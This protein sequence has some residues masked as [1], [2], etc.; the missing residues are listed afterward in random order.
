MP[1]SFH[2]A[3]L[4]VAP[5]GMPHANPSL[6]LGL[7]MATVPAIPSFLTWPQLPRRSFREQRFVQSAAGFPGLVIDSTSRRV[8]VD[9]AIAERDLDRLSLAYL[10]HDIS[11]GAL[12]E[13]YAAGLKEALQVPRSRFEGV[14]VR[15]MLVGP[16]SLGLK[17]ADEQERPLVYDPMLLEA[18]THHLSLRAS[19]LSAQF[20]DQADTTIICLDEPFLDAIHSPFLPLDWDRSIDMLELVFAGVRGGRGLSVGAIGPRQKEQ[21]PPIHWEQLM[22]TSM[23]CFACDVYYRQ[24]ILLDAAPV[25]PAFLNRRGFVIWGLIPAQE[26]ALALETAETLVERFQDLVHELG[27]VGVPQDLLVPASA[28]STSGGLEHLSVALAERAMQLCVE[29]SRL[30][31]LAYGFKDTEGRIRPP[32]SRE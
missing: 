1:R 31:R 16:I 10:T 27:A 24:D 28:I 5:G 12:T 7:V 3:C 11:A 18:L 22:E 17:L 30:L 13:E 6:A 32:G 20:N 14:V 15:S 2:P 29:V 8:Y 9:R 23:E 26:E 19:W 25:L 4:P 21:P